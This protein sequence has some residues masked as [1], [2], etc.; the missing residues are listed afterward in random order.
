MQ[1]ATFNKLDFARQRQGLPDRAQCPVCHFFDTDDAEVRRIL[2]ERGRDLEWIRRFAHCR[3]QERSALKQ[4][5]DAQRLRAANLPH[6]N[7]PHRTFAN[8]LPRNGAQEARA[9]L[10]EF[11]SVS[12]FHVAAL[13]GISGC[14]KSHLLEAAG[15]SLIE[16]GVSARYELCATLMDRL[17]AAHRPDAKENVWALMDF[18]RSFD[19]LLID[20]VG[21]ERGTD[22]AVEKLTEIVDERLR[23]GR[24]L[25]LATNLTHDELAERLGDRL[26][27]RLWDRSQA[28]GVRHLT[29]TAGDYRAGV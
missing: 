8:F 7:G 13:V 18:Y 17:R 22:F 4:A 27:S 14:G 1:L 24:K 11:V 10:E 12:A 19:A 16:R 26:A 3:C 21:L 6:S 9:L 29:I 5:D 25:A 2:L 28:A 20:D 23:S 15:R